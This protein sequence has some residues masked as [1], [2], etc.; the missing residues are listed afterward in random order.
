MSCTDWDEL[1]ERY[2]DDELTSAER[3]RVVEHLASC[4]RCDEYLQHLEQASTLLSLPGR[5]A[6]QRVDFDALWGRISLAIAEPPAQPS[7]AARVREWLATF[8]GANRRV[9][10]AAGV[11]SCVTLLV[12]VPLLRSG[13]RGVAPAAPPQGAPSVAVNEV[14]VDSLQSG[15][16][17]MVL[18]NVHPDDA[19]TVIWLLEDE[20]APPDAGVPEAASSGSATAPAV[21]AGQPAPAA[22]ALG[23]DLAEPLQGTQ[24]LDA[25]RRAA[26]AAAADEE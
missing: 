13:D 25:A 21:P 11:A 16:H 26:A 3:G 1:L 10:L 9:L 4:Q 22:S 17:D 24:P 5:E 19:T 2:R 14:I 8:W 12:A 18:V 23:A 20:A 7:V 15:E 6:A